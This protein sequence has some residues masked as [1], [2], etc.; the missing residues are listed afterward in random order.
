M[1]KGGGRE[2]G[3]TSELSSARKT[4]EDAASSGEARTLSSLDV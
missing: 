4:V 2:T 1:K 3:I